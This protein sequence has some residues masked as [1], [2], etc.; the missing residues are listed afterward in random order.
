L[1]PS[2]KK[3][4]LKRPAPRLRRIALLRRLQSAAYGDPVRAAVRFAPPRSEGLLKGGGKVKPGKGPTMLA[5][6]LYLPLF[7]ILISTANPP[8]APQAFRCTDFT[9]HYGSS[10][11]DGK[12]TVQCPNGTDSCVLQMAGNTGSITPD[13]DHAHGW[14]V[15]GSLGEGLH[16]TDERKCTFLNFSNKMHWLREPPY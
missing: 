12:A 13:P 11:P 10:N 9:G 6:R 8:A 16:M 5:R 2:P 14:F 1:F 15:H 3:L 7:L 4:W